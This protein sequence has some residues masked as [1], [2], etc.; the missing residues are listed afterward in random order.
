VKINDTEV[1]SRSGLVGEDM[2]VWVKAE[3][4]SQ[5][6]IEIGEGAVSVQPK[7]KPVSRTFGLVLD[8][9]GAS[10]A[11]ALRIPLRAGIPS[12]L[13]VSV[14]TPGG[15]LVREIDLPVAPGA[16]RSRIG[17]DG[18]DMN[19]APVRAG[20]YVVKVRAQGIDVALPMTLLN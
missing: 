14:Y 6:K 10:R 1:P 2:V 17:W 13:A 5:A 3:I 11:S 19:G 16:G 4:S 7:G 9:P 18:R 12:R 15:R 20:A 8:V